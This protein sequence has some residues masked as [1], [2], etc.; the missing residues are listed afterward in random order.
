[1]REKY[2]SLSLSVLRDLA[3]ARGMKGISA[4]KKSDLIERM[5]QEDQKEETKQQ[6][7]TENSREIRVE[8]QEKQ[9]KQERETRMPPDNHRICC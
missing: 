3:K 5:L 1:M 2:E 4:L 8:R 6:K 9:E 7:E